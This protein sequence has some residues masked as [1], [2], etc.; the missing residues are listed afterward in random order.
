[1]SMKVG[2]IDESALEA[3]VLQ[4]YAQ[5]DYVVRFGPEIVPGEPGAERERHDEAFLPDRLR[6][7]L[8]ALN[9]DIPA[10]ALND[11]YRKITLSPSPSLT[12][13]NHQFHQ[14]LVDGID[15]QYRN[16]DGRDVFDKVRVLD[17]DDMDANDW[18]VVNQFSVVE[19]NCHRRADVVVFV[20]GLPLAVLELKSPTSETATARSGHDQLQTYRNEIP[21]LFHHNEVLVASDGMDTR[22][23]TLTGSW[24]WFLPWKTVEGDVVSPQ[25]MSSLEVLVKG[26]FE[27]RRFL[28]LVR[29]FIVFESDGAQYE[30]KMALYHQYHAVNK[31]VESA[32][33]ASSAEG[34]GRAGVVWH[35]QGSGKSLSMVFF[36]GKL[37][38]REEMANPTLVVITDRIDL[39]N[40]LFGVF[41]RC[42]EL[43]RQ[44]PR[45]A[46]DREHLKELLQVPS[47]GVIFTTL[48]KFLAEPG[49]T[50]PCL[51]DRRNVVVI[52]DE[53]HRSHYGFMK[54]L[55]RAMRDALPNASF[56]AFTGTPIELIGKHT[57]QVF[58]DYLDRYDIRQA[59]EDEATVPIYYEG[60]LIP[61]NLSP[62]EEPLLDEEFD[63]ITEDEE[64]DERENLKSRWSRLEKLV[65]AEDRVERLAADLVA[66]FEQ[67]LEVMNGKGMVVC[68]SR[69]ICVD[70]YNE[71]IAL[72]PD[73]HA[74]DDHEGFVKVVMTGS[75]SDPVGW[76]QHVRNKNRRED[77][78]KRFKD[79]ESPFRLAIV[80]DMWLTGFD[81][82]PLHTMYVDKPMQGHGLMQTI[83][84]VNRVYPGKPGGL[85]VDY[86]GI[87]AKLKQALDY[88][89]SDE[90]EAAGIDQAKAVD[91]LL[92][93]L[94][95]LRGLLH[96]FDYSAAVGADLTTM[97]PLAEAAVEHILGQHVAEGEQP[98][99]KLFLR[100]V[101]GMSEAFALAVP[102]ERALDV[103]DEV[104]FLQLVRARTIKL[105]KSEGTPE[106]DI[107]T[108][109]Q[110]MLSRAVVSG[111]VI[112]IFSEAGLARPDIS[113]LSD[114]FLREVQGMEHKN[115]AAEA[116]RK[117][118]EGRIRIHERRNPLQAR[119]F[120]EM[121]KEAM[122]R[123]HNRVIEAAEVIEE[124][125]AL[126]HEIRDAEQRGEEM[127]LTDDELAFYDA[128][129]ENESAVEV[130]GDEQL[131]IIARELLVVVRENAT[132]DWAQR[133][134]VRAK[135]RVVC[136]R[137]LR[138]HGYPPDLQQSATETVLEQAEMLCEGWVGD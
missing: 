95:V 63:D 47:G 88:Y 137:I 71:I 111:E 102:D 65:G 127:G 108:A 98:L 87:A 41:S 96:G 72:R 22:A 52:C 50:Y 124:L 26:I 38:Q 57:V 136:K 120:A 19:D 18:L 14:M 134:A 3:S 24:E 13:T 29:N 100:H 40:Q 93:E 123:Y 39:D 131:M 35:T 28:D 118:L 122:R 36:A 94:D 51:S 31:A 104:R 5:S 60:R 89:S 76:Q 58:G 53:A 126:A 97:L 69:R 101:K 92:D 80:R 34:D 45:Q 119:S 85:I 48:Q 6:D 105:T 46:K 78:A 59:V 15:V 32:V 125:L 99:R 43:L 64:D 83:A 114:E 130:M 21:A 109:I 135:L 2:V 110:Q 23:G 67:R 132:I 84:R 55:A 1:M 30:K 49:A 116:L 113:V 66:H 56:I 11:A 9:P 10:E 7:A 37:I 16:E 74:D 82:P 4:W 8:A 103:R 20:N 73:W 77:L 61:L 115:L 44:E 81:A 91:L 106:E 68:M 62:D 42:K 138:K 54:G 133:E 86:L 121:L 128:L 107:E 12:E 33:A 25:G 117:L 70:V 75:A 79:P 129:A 27:K 90:R 17:F 112:D